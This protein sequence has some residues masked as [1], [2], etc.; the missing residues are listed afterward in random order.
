MDIRQRGD[1]DKLLGFAGMTLVDAENGAF[2]SNEA[3]F[4]KGIQ[5]LAYYPQKDAQDLFNQAL[6]ELRDYNWN[7]TFE[8]IGLNLD[9]YDVEALN[10][11][12][13]YSPKDLVRDN[14]YEVL[15]IVNQ[16]DIA[17][18]DL[19]IEQQKEMHAAVV[20]AAP[21]WSKLQDDSSGWQ[22]FGEDKTVSFADFA[23]KD[24]SIPDPPQSYPTRTN[25]SGKTL[26]I[27]GS[28]YE[29]VTPFVF[30]EKTATE[31]RSPLVTYEGT[32]HAPLAGFENECLTKIF[33]D[34]L[35]NNVDP[36]AASCKP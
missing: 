13:E 23:L 4:L 29:S 30:A 18:P 20:K 34:Y 6:D 1:D 5:T 31:L 36:I 16:M 12:T 25:T 27:V 33:V 17:W 15:L 8:W 21:F 24:D 10:G 22:Y 35:V 2:K 32:E 19:T 28:K 3:L 7:G 14:S 26:L 11:R 9:G